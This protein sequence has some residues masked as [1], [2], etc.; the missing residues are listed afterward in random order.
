[1]C[2][3]NR[4]LGWAEKVSQ[5]VAQNPN[6]NPEGVSQICTFWRWW[7]VRRGQQRR[8]AL[9]SSCS[10][11]GHTWQQTPPLPRCTQQDAKSWVQKAP[12]ATPPDLY[13]QSRAV[14]PPLAKRSFCLP[15]R[16][17]RLELLSEAQH[18][19]SPPPLG[20]ARALCPPAQAQ[21]FT[22]LP[23]APIPSQ[24]RDKL[25]LFGCVFS[26]PR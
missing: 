22:P 20:Y 6:S 18:S 21:T 12:G 26:H 5:T 8:D 7:R 3:H 11:Q 15:S 17:A 2:I 25:C 19:R 14:F 9:T 13:W 10:L 4:S 1:M 23:T 24:P 16:A